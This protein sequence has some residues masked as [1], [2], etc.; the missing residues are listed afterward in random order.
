MLI[1]KKVEEKGG[2]EKAIEK[3]AQALRLSKERIRLVWT[4]AQK[5]Q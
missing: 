1:I 3:V 4:S 2:D 5:N